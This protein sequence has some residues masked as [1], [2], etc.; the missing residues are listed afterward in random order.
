[1]RP[2]FVVAL[3]LGLASPLAAQ[4]RPAPRLGWDPAH[5][6]VFA[7]GVIE[8]QNGLTGYAQQGRRDVELV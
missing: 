7:A 3:V 6:W 8:F 5:T 1:M 4:D 2:A